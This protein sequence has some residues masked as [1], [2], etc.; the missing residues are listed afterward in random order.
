LQRG[1]TVNGLAKLTIATVV[2][3]TVGSSVS[4]F[5]VPPPLQ[6]RMIRR[7]IQA[8]RL[9]DE[10]TQQVWTYHEE[11]GSFPPGDGA[12]TAELVRALGTLSH[13]GG[14]YW[15]F[16]PEMLTPAG[17]LRNPVSPEGEVLYYR[18]NRSR[19]ALDPRA[20][21]QTSFDLWGKGAQGAPERIN[22]WDSVVSS[23]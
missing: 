15:M 1:I 8:Q 23:P 5:F 17:D 3:I 9:V 13:S 22:N 2:I 19:P 7:Q 14:P 16:P 20:H 18:N 6:E 21:N 11:Q 4:I 12:G 10:L